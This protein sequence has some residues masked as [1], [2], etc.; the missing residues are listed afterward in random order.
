MP[1]GQGD[2]FETQFKH[3]AR[4]DADHR[5]EFFHRGSAHD[6][7][8][9]AHLLIG[10]PR[11][12]FG[13]R[14]QRALAGVRWRVPD[15]EGVIAVETGPAAMTALRI[16]QHC[17]D[18]EGVDFP[19]PPDPHVLGATDAVERVPS[20][21]HHAFDPELARCFPLPGEV[22]PVFSGQQRRGEQQWIVGLGDHLLQLTAPSALRL[23]APVRAFPFQ[24]VVGE[25][26]HRHVIENLAG[27]VLTADPL[28]QQGERLHGGG[29]RGRIKG[30]FGRRSSGFPGNDFPVDH[31]AVGQ[32]V[33][34]A[35]E[36]R[37]AIGDQFFTPRPDPQ[38]PLALDDL[39]PDAV[40]LPFHLPMAG[41]TE[42]RF[43]LFDRL[44]QGMG[45]EKRIR[46]TAA[47]RMLVGRLRGD[48]LQVAGGTRPVGQVGVAHHP[49]GHALAVQLRHG[50]QGPGHQ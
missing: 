43:K 12:G 31:G 9:L 28:L 10:Q 35:V 20:L 44:R 47:L 30:I 40:P 1:F 34:Q 3:Q 11:I 22:E 45:E 13:E 8:D 15:G 23:V 25:D 50:G 33:D 29:I 49:L 21:E 26:D 41:G 5:A 27:E 48:Q 19:F 17:V 14:H 7:V 42:Q 18:T 37:K 6:A 39:G 32:A 46:L 38:A 24:Q 16:N 4:L 36:F 2:A